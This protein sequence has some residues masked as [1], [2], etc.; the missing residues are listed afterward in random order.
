MKFDVRAV[1]S[2]PTVLALDEDT[3]LVLLAL[4]R[5]ADRWGEVESKRALEIASTTLAGV[6]SE[7][8]RAAVL[9]RLHTVRLA[10]HDKAARRLCLWTPR[11]LDDADA[12][13]TTDDELAALETEVNG[14]I[15]G[16]TA[17][18]SARVGR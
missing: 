1:T 6:R 13:G 3:R 14:P 18:Q 12:F 17:A 15:S 2:H 9:T 16:L 11:A 10:H 5:E 4:L 8:T 7:Q